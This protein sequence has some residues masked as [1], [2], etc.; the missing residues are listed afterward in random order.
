MSITQKEVQHIAHLAR[1]ALTVEEEEKFAGELSAILGFV[2]EL[3]EVDTEGVAPVNG[4]TDLES[5]MRGDSEIDQT[6]DKK[7]ADVFAAVP[8]KKENW[9]KVKSVFE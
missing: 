2:E 5:V 1:I 6:L 3:N 9:I 7:A 4:G 8:E